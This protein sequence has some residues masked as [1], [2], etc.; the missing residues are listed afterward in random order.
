[1]VMQAHEDTRS[2]RQH[3]SNDVHYN[4]TH[5]FGHKATQNGENLCAD[6]RPRPMYRHTPRHLRGWVLIVQNEG[7]YDIPYIA[8]RSTPRW[9]SFEVFADRSV[10]RNFY[11]EISCAIGLAMQDSVSFNRECFSANQSLV[12]QP[13][14]FSTSNDLQYTVL[15]MLQVILDLYPKIQDIDIR[16]RLMCNKLTYCLH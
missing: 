11:S 12:L 13:R 3:G 5:S 1:M 15:S 10:P 2:T 6:V 14:N 4:L 8:N 16:Y 7:S 9:K